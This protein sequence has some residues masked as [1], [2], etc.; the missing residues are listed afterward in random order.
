MLRSAGSWI[1]APGLAG[2]LASGGGMKTRPLRLENKLDALL[3]RLA[4]KRG[5]SVN[6]VVVRAIEKEIL[7]ENEIP[8]EKILQ[9]VRRI[10][11][12]PFEI[13]KKCICGPADLK[14][15]VP[16]KNCPRHKE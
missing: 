4:E 10:V 6:Q 16:R 9:K 2:P 1:R 12:A 3:V 8:A 13:S 5:E 14:L 7:T 11:N 15:G